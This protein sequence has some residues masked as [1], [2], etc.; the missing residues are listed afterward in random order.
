MAIRIN[1]TYPIKHAD[2][3]IVIGSKCILHLLACL[4]QI[5]HVQCV[6]VIEFIEIIRVRVLILSLLLLLVGLPG[7]LPSLSEWIFLYIKLK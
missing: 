7:C 4:T 3:L 2:A 1:L 5:L 6:L